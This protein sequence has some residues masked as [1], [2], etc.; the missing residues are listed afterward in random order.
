MIPSKKINDYSDA[1]ELGLHGRWT[2]EVRMSGL[3]R[4]A[5]GC[6]GQSVL[7]L[8]AAEGLVAR[9]FLQHGATMLHGFEIMESRVAAA[10]RICGEFGNAGF[11][12]ADLS[13]WNAF[14]SRNADRLRSVYD[15][16]L[17]LGLNHHL[18][19]S[20]RKATI[21]GAAAMSAG[22]FALRTTDACYNEERIAE[23]L[24]L[25]GFE[26]SEENSNAAHPDLGPV[27]IFRRCSHYARGLS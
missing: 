13:D 15:I 17:Y 3:E 10:C 12:Q 26:L 27:R 4:L 23:S 7:D 19:A 9:R 14:R 25:Q 18:P 1:P 16:V 5:A 11:W 20:A 6:S 22:I 24:R 2:L 21:D 8:G